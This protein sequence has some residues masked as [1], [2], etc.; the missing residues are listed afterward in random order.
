MADKLEILVVDDEDSLRILIRNELEEKGFAVSEAATGEDALERLAEKRFTV[1]I[2]DIRLPGIDGLEVLK[3][4]REQ[5][6]AEKVI[7]LTGV[8]ELKI[9]RDSLKFGADDFLTKPYSFSNLLTC[10]D[11]VMRE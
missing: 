3:K 9:A 1:V 11:R 5:N 7:M 2:L 8:E 10:I 6:L 4:I